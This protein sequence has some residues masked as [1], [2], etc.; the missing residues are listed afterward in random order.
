R[1][2]RL[3]AAAQ[4]MR[5]R[6]GDLIGAAVAEGGKTIPEA[7]PE[8]S[9][10]IDFTEFYPLSVKRFFDPQDAASDGVAPRGRGVVVVVSPWNFPIAIPCGGIAAA[11]AAGNTVILKPSLDTPLVAWMICQCF[12]DAGVPADALQFLPCATTE[13]AQQ[14]VSH[15][16]VDAVVLTGGTETARAILR[17]KREIELIAETGGKNT[18]I[19]TALADRDQ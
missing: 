14:L 16:D 9:E 7:D 2:A 17:S 19:V 12:W 10:A 18:T 11:L 5:V 1:H 4:W 13:I 6:R 8:V 3:R 15:D